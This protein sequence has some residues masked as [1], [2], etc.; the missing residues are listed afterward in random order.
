MATAAAAYLAFQLPVESDVKVF[1]SP[2][3][4]FV[5]SLDKLDRH[6]GS[7]GGEPAEVYVE[8]DLTS[9]DSI[10]AIHRF[11]DA[12]RR[13][14]TELLARD[15][16]GLVVVDTGAAQLLADVLDS[17]AARVATG[18]AAGVSLTDD[19]NDGVPDSREQIA[20]IYALHTEG[21]RA[22]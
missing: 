1:F 10:A 13:L 15:D 21:G 14:D 16:E 2:D 20:A 3:T 22:V 11:A 18:S 19:D 6:I 4:D 8:G 17:Q 5:T 9:P 12:A 7:S